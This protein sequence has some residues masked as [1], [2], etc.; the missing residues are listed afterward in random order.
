MRLVV[1]LRNG[2]QIKAEVESFT[3]THNKISGDLR[4][5]KWA[6]GGEV[7]TAIN[8]LDLAEVVAVHAEY[9]RGDKKEDPGYVGETPGEGAGR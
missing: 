6:A 5:I 9:E 4:G 3:V 7:A 1:T 2:V 8:W